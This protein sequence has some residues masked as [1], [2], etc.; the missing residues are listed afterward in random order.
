MSFFIKMQ[1]ALILLGLLSFSCKPDSTKNQN[2]A[3][4]ISGKAETQSLIIETPVKDSKYPI[5]ENVVINYSFKDTLKKADSIIFRINGKRADKN[6]LP[7]KIFTWETK[8]DKPGIKNLTVTAFYS[9]ST[10]ENRQVKINLVSDIKP[11]L[12]TYNIVK[13]YPHDIQAYTQGLIFEDGFL[14]EGT[15]Q[16]GQSTLR[17]VKLETGERVKILNLPPDI[18]GEG[19]ASTGKYLY[20][21][22]YKS[23][24]AFQYD[25]N[26]FELVNRFTY[27]M[28]E[29]WGLTFD[30]KNLIM[31]DGSEILYFLD[32]EYFTEIKR[33]EVYD[34][35]GPINSLNEL[36]FINNEIWANVYTTDTILRIDPLT[37]KVTGK[38]IMSNLLRQEDYHSNIDYFNGIAYDKENDRLFVTGKNWPKLFEIKI[39]KK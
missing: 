36:E 24:V 38:L 26:T 37:G 8:N 30:G 11:Q 9:D 21:L 5:G 33:I 25:K 12:Y 23:N 27:P 32:P 39:V 13:S 22:T 16:T 29:G 4:E 2:S 20:Q 35:N 15:G 34:D 1:F 19:L 14:Y 6:S 18:F 31:S 10:I 28:K 3:T 7:E 17:K